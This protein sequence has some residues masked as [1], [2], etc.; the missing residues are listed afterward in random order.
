MITTNS[1]THPPPEFEKEKE[2][3]KKEKPM[4]PMTLISKYAS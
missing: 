2:K 3:K 4:L 1:C